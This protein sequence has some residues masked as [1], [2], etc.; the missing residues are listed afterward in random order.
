MTYIA[1]SLPITDAIVAALKTTGRQI[2][3]GEKPSSPEKPPPSF[4]PY[5]VVH[6]GIVRL[7]GSALAPLEDAVHA[8]QVTSVGLDA[9][10]AVRMRDEAKAVLLDPGIDLPGFVPIWR[11][12]VTSRPVERDDTVKPPLF[13]AIDVVH[14]KV[15]PAAGG[16]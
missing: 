12:L 6:T 5:A 11:Q 4:Y 15:T 7:E 3:N 13:Y 16:S 14:I 9:R 1:E 10:G 2:G 8:V